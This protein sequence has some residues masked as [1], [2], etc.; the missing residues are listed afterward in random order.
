MET[1]AIVVAIVVG[2]LYLAALAYAITQI[3]RM[4]GLNPTEKAIWIVAILAFPLGGAIIWFI[5][6]P[7]PFGIRVGKPTL[8]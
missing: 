6:G 7:H 3:A 2:A 1:F 5:L 4:S 8:K